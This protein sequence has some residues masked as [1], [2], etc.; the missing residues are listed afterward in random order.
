MGCDAV[1]VGDDDLLFGKETLLEILKRGEFPVVSANLLDSNTRNALFRPYVIKAIEGFRIGILGVSPVPGVADRR[2]DGLTVEDPMVRVRSVIPTLREETDFIILISHLG[3]PKD[4]EL[5]RK[6]DGINVI[7]GGH[8]G[9]NL[10]YPRIIQNTVVLQVANKGRYL[11]RV[12]LS[13]TDPTLPVVNL[14]IKETLQKRLAHLERRLKGLDEKP[15]KS[16]KDKQIRARFARQKT[17]TERVLK[18][19]EQ[20]NKMLNKIVPLRDT[21]KDHPEC[22]RIL[23]PYLSRISKL[24]ENSRPRQEASPTP[25]TKESSD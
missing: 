5:A 2:F 20:S 6:I 9:I 3:Y 1:T 21:I 19:Y 22:Q 4:L 10:N 13:I 14:K 7:V 8:T 15:T 24:R 25:Q 18:T 11:G 17:E 23:A 12:D 16:E